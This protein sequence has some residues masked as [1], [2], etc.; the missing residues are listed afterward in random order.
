[1][2]N[3]DYYI[4]AARKLLDSLPDLSGKS[5]LA[6]IR[7][8]YISSLLVELNLIL[9]INGIDPELIDTIIGQYKVVLTKRLNNG[10]E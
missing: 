9:Q 3:D 1:V 4:D 5:E 10:Q 8:D 7:M 6:A 2:N